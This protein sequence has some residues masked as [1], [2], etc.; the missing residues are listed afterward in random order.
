MSN[1]YSPKD[2]IH[3]S[4][5][6]GASLTDSPVSE[7]IG[8]SGNGCLNMRVDFVVSGVT[9]TTAITA[10]L[11]FR[12]NED[13]SW[14]NAASANSSVSITADGGY[15]LKL[16]AFRAADQADMPL[17]KMCRLVVTTGVGDAVTFDA[18]YLS[19]EL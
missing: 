1:G 3:E 11:Q 19:Q 5:S 9:L 6:K 7:E 14:A 8:L 17:P 2:Y 10:R 18:L 4:V 12:T 13:F 15:S 16:S